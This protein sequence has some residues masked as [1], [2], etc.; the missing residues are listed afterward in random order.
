MVPINAII[1]AT[2]RLLE[3]NPSALFFM[4]KVTVSHTSDLLQHRTLSTTAVRLVSHFIA[5]SRNLPEALLTDNHPALR[6]D[7]VQDIVFLTFASL[8]F[9]CSRLCS[10]LG[11]SGVWLLSISISQ[12]KCTL[13]IIV[14]L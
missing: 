6:R 13:G 4:C 3:I 7:N 10:S 5:F 11:W 14:G 1:P 2:I 9:L 8:C 12:V